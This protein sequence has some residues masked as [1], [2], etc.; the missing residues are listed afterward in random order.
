M[1]EPACTNRSGFAIF[2]SVRSGFGSGRTFSVGIRDPENHYFR[3]THNTHTCAWREQSGLQSGDAGDGGGA[4]R[5]CDA[6]SYRT[7]RH[8]RDDKNTREANEQ[9]TQ[10]DRNRQTL[11]VETSMGVRKRYY[12]RVEGSNAKQRKED[13]EDRWREG[14]HVGLEDSRNRGRSWKPKLTF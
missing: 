7:L 11:N 5:L 12:K 1:A 6:T 3:D 14:E 2:K 4:G 10:Q 13:T 8:G 9:P